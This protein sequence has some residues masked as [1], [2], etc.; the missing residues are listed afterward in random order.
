MSPL[1]A[2]PVRD[3]AGFAFLTSVLPK[4]APAAGAAIPFFFELT[5]CH[6]SS[7]SVD[8]VQDA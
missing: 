4:F 6:P 3:G 2:V 8:I 5:T 1:L 7:L